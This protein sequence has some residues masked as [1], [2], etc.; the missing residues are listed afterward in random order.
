MRHKRRRAALCAVGR[1]PRA[2]RAARRITRDD[3]E[4]GSAASGAI[5]SARRPAAWR[6]VGAS[7]GALRWRR[8][9]RAARRD[10]CDADRLARAGRAQR[11]VR[12]HV[13]AAAR[14]HRADS[15]LL[16]HRRRGEGRT[17][18]RPP[19]KLKLLVHSCHPASAPPPARRASG[20]VQWNICPSLY[21]SWFIH[22]STAVP[23]SSGK[24]NKN[25]KNKKQKEKQRGLLRGV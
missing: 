5:G 18:H 6:R 11:T 15:R 13:C 3:D 7:G 9:G 20:T 22:S 25:N 2:R 23:P 21:I 14:T 4:P 24:T 8:R 17:D 16:G 1:R 12:A 19:T 10:R